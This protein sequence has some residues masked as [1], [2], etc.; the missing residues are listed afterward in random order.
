MSSLT[1]RGELAAVERTLFDSCG[2]LVLRRVFD[3]EEI[4][5][6]D[7]LFEKYSAEFVTRGDGVSTAHSDFFKGGSVCAGIFEHP[8]LKPVIQ[9]ICGEGFR[10]D[11]LPLAFEQHPGGEGFDLHGGRLLPSGHLN[12]PV[13]YTSVDNTSVQCSL[14]TVSI[15]ITDMPLGAGGFVTLPGSHKSSFPLTDDIRHA[16]HAAVK[17]MLVQ[18]ALEAGD[19]LLFTEALIHGTLPWKGRHTRRTLLLRFAP[20]TCAYARGYL[21]TSAEVSKLDLSDSV[22]EMLKPPYHP[23]FDRSAAVKRS[24]D[25]LDY[26]ERVFGRPYY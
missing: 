20:A 18:P 2:Y 26:D 17:D 19:V 7:G 22:K 6:L 21:E 14:L 8:R 11:H 16:R 10:L 1:A 24:S 15:A 9:E 25:Q 5:E 23:R 12:Y 4:G 3:K 13:L